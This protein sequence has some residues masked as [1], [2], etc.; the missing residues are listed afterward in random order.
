MDLGAGII[1][2]VPGHAVFEV[3]RSINARVKKFFIFIY[4][5]SL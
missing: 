2:N 4:L 5:Y 3:I 1:L